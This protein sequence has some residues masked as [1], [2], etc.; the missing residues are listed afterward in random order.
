MVG[1]RAIQVT[2]L[3]GPE[4][5]VPAEV[6]D[7]TAGPGQVVVEVSVAGITFVETMIRRGVGR[8]HASPDLPYV[9]GGIVAGRV[10]QVGDGVDRRWSGRR[11][12]A[13]TGQTGGFAELAVAAVGGLLPVPDGLGLSEAAALHT[14]GSTAL[15]L[16]EGARIRTGEWVLVEAAGG[17]VGSLLVQLARAAGARVVGAARGPRKLNLV[18]D[19][20]A[21][22]VVDYSEPGWAMQVLEVTGGGA[23]VVFDGVGGEIGR[24]A[25]RVTA[26]GGRFSVHG[27]SSGDSTVIDPAEAERLGV[28]VIGIE[29]LFGFGPRMRGWVE[30]VLADATAGRI[31]PVIGQTFPLERAADAHAAI[32]ARSVL[33]KTLLLM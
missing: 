16:V 24:A 2:S 11:V 26:K 5:L 4:V 27:A 25:F 33:G 13:E 31:R 12:L 10:R 32:E 17:G 23:D 22:A 6:P 14:D 18:R 20:G 28:R 21:D 15:G 1:I 9:P 7:P 19:L 30:R 29:Q 8:W 3:G